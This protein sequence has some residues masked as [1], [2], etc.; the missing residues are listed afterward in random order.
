MNMVSVFSTALMGLIIGLLG[1]GIMPSGDKGGTIAAACA[2]LCGA[3]LTASIGWLMDF[4]AIGSVTGYIA[5]V[6]GSVVLLIVYRIF[7]GLEV[8][9]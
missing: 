6:A 7:S 2:G 9:A 8:S 4:W 1:R 3:S 5:G